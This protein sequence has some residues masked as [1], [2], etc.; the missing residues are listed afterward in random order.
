M[1][2]FRAVGFLLWALPVAGTASGEEWKFAFTPAAAR[3]GFTLA[4]GDLRFEAGQGFGFVQREGAPPVFAVAVPEG[5]Y[6]VTVRLGHPQEATE[7]TLRAEARRLMLHSVATQAE[8]EVTR[9]FT[10]NVKR[11]DIAGGGRVSVDNRE[12]GAPNWDEV[13][14]VEVQGRAPGLV[15]MEIKPAPNALTIFLAGDSTVNDQPQGPYFGWGQM[16]PRFFQRGVAVSN[17][18]QSGL[19]LHSFE[20]QQR[21]RKILTMMKPGDYLFIQ[22]GH[23]DQ[24]DKAE[25]AGPFTTYKSNLKRF[26]DAVRKKGGF[27]VLVTPME[28]RRWTRGTLQTTLDAYAEAVR[29]TGAEEQVPLIDLQA[30]S[31]ALYRALGPDGSKRAFVHY[32]ANALPGHPEAIKDDSHHSAFGGYELAR[33]VVEGIRQ[34]IPA[35]AAKLAADAGVFDPARPDDPATLS[36]PMSA[37]HDPVEKPA[38]N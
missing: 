21:L 4:G 12:K 2:S 10:V 11:P 16:L 13:L 27:P 25:G 30:M 24:K 29:Q 33:C 36:L 17:H 1:L 3:P 26:I 15:S 22:F 37:V 28:R 8:Q 20:R 38:G 23:N 7:T 5:N 18:A 35:L 32:P 34:A 6:D 14:T 9:T 31:I 19:A